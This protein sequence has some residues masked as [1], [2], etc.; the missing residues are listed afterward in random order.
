ML[1]TTISH[2][3]QTLKKCSNNDLLSPLYSLFHNLVHGEKIE[4]EGE[5]DDKKCSMRGRRRERWMMRSVALEGEEE[6]DEIKEY[7]RNIR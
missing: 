4:R 6:R 1:H 2:H 5:M 3:G 7:H